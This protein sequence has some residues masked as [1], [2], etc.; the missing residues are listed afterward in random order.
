M[1][2]QKTL[3][4]R[5][6]PIVIA[7][8]FIGTTGAALLR[9]FTSSPQQPEPSTA[10]QSVPAAQQLQAQKRGYELVLEREP[11]NQVALQGLVEI[12]LAMGDY[13]GAIAPLEKLVA[14]NPGQESYKALLDEIK[15]RAGDP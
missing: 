7:C 6:L 11:E 10:P 4:R 8:A 15:Q 3:L 14:L 1:A 12:Q 5:V 2:T 13:G 9:T